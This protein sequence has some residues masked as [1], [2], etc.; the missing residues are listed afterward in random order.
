MTFK[1][2]MKIEFCFRT[3]NFGRYRLHNVGYHHTGTSIKYG[4]TI[5][6]LFFYDAKNGLKDYISGNHNFQKVHVFHIFTNINWECKYSI[7]IASF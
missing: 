5:E 4:I 2:T 7:T 3:K 1:H 6:D